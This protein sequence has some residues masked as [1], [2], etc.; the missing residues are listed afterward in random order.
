MP[1]CRATIRCTRKS[2]GRES[3]RHEAFYLGAASM[4]WPQNSG[5]QDM[6]EPARRHAD[7]LA[8]PHASISKFALAQVAQIFGGVNTLSGSVRT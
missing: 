2:E 4:T 1:F 3:R 7:W 8:Q 5:G 6:K